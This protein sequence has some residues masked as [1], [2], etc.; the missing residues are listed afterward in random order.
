MSVIP[1][2][3]LSLQEFNQLIDIKLLTSALT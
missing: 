2:N 1:A 3:K